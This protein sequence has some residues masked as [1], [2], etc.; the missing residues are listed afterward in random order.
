MKAA[1]KIVIW[2]DFI[3]KKNKLRMTISIQPREPGPLS[4]DERKQ[5]ADFFFALMDLDPE[6]EEKSKE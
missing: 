4:L 5:L 1:R 2:R 6:K 3:M